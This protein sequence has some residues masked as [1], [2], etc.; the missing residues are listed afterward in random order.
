MPPVRCNRNS[1]DIFNR[2]YVNESLT[3]ESVNAGY[4]AMHRK[5]AWLTSEYLTAD[6]VRTVVLCMQEAIS[7]RAAN[8]YL[9]LKCWKSPSRGWAV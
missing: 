8:G 2:L 1:Q 9:V 4:D 3:E 7:V 5:W 6:C